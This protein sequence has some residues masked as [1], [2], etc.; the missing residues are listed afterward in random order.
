M[1]CGLI[2]TFRIVDE[3]DYGNEIFSI[4]SSARVNQRVNAIA[5]V[6]LQRVFAKMS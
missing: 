2:E 4:L 1:Q 5:V 6:I 3:G